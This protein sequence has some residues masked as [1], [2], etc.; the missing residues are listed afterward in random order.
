M[1]ILELGSVQIAT[2]RRIGNAR[3]K[4][5]SFRHKK[6]D[7]TLL[8]SLRGRAAAANRDIALA[9]VRVTQNGEILSKAAGLKLMDEPRNNR[10]PMPLN[11]K[12]KDNCQ[13][14]RVR[15]DCALDNGPSF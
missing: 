11:V 7:Q 4:I 2:I 10:Y 8:S 14:G 15:L 3:T 1:S 6:L 12:G 5:D 9:T 13:I